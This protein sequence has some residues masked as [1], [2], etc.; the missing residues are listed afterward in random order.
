MHCF[1]INIAPELYILSN[2][3]KQIEKYTFCLFCILL[4]SKP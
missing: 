1:K 3:Q 2:F 4:S